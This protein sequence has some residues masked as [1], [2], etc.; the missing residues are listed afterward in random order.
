[1]SE[2]PEVVVLVGIPASGKSTFYRE[3]FAA[4]HALVSKDLFPNARR[5]DARQARLLDEA[6]T[7]GRSLVVD[8]T[9][10]AVEDRAPILEA[11]RR[12]GA[13]VVGYY[14]A[15]P[16]AEA[17][18]RNAAREGRARVP[19]AGV[20]SIAKKRVRPRL[21]EGFDAL[22]F[23]RLVGTG[24]TVEAWKEEADEAR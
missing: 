21:A 10:P 9:S 5:R 23:V 3:R 14:F 15:T 19:D 16:L 7:A 22:Y 17:M 6:L 1:V 4:T 2:A 11:A 12:H 13:R 18:A 24:F 20:R 8:N